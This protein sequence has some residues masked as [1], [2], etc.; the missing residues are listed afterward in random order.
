M[1]GSTSR[2]QRPYGTRYKNAP[3]IFAVMKC[4]VADMGVPGAFR[5]NNSSN[6]RIYFLWC[7]DPPRVHCALYT[8]AQN[9]LVENALARTMNAGLAARLEVSKIFPSVHL[10]GGKGVRDQI[11]TKLWLVP[12]L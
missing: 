11:G 9:G 6:Y 5:T 3:A 8:G 12:V 10:D 7:R 4:F 1:V 2:L